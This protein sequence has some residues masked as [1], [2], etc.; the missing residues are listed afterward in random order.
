[1]STVAIVPPEVRL[2]IVRT[3]REWLGTPYHHRA[4]V[5]GAGA[6]C[7]MFPLAVYKECGLIPAGYE[8]PEYAMQWHLHRSEELYIKELEKFCRPAL[9]PPRPGDFVV[10]R[11]GRTFSHGA[12]VLAWPLVIHS[13][14]PHGVL[15]ADA[16]RDGEL[17]GREM[18]IFEFVGCQGVIRSVPA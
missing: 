5:K 9:G 13:A 12:I 15:L 11:F 7:A 1:M 16:E 4:A 17:M 14:I 8:P 3:A 18:K 6:D 2:Q 10:F